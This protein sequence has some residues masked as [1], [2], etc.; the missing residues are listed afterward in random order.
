M[1]AGQ[2]FGKAG[3]FVSLMIFSRILEDAAFGELLLSVSIGL[4]IVFLSDMGVT[5]IVTRKMS[6]GE[7]TDGVFTDALVVRTLLSLLSITLVMSAVTLA[8]YSP[9]QVFLVLLVSIGFI[10]DGYCESTFALFRAREQMVYEGAVRVLH[11]I[12]GIGLSA[13]AWYSGKGVVFAASTYII[14]EI[15]ALMFA[16]AVVFIRMKYRPAPGKDIR[17][18]IRTLFIAAIP[19]GL[20]GIMIAAGQRLDSVFI[21]AFIGDAAIAAY[22]QCLK[23]FETLVLIVVPTLIPGALFPALC[24]AVQ[25]GWGQARMR[26]AWMTELFL[27][28]AFVLVIPLWAAGQNVLRVIWG[29]DFL[30]GVSPHDVGT[31]FKIVLL[32]LPV[33]YM[34]HMFMATVIAT[35][36]QRKVL[37]AVF[38]SLVLEALL[39]VLLIPRF[40]I[41][42]A[43][44]AHLLFLTTATFQMVWILKKAYG[45]T[46]FLRG[47]VRPVA[48]FIPA[49]AVLTAAPFGGILSGVSAIAVFTAV[50]I[51][52]GGLAIV[53]S[54]ARKK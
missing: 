31:T 14:R 28:I 32:T 45:P 34:F 40:G 49:V 9:R 35:N 19:L 25:D 51:L 41:P 17:R 8:G 43:A 10:L 36:R 5:M 20:A 33:A 2:V 24:M 11:G 39:F 7:P 15:P 4:I 21:K 54:K 26:I 16:F 37:S 38:L 46:G 53:P 48:S 50:W 42:G 47:A 12:L 1:L 3:L 18:R 13:F 6:T 27:V 22:Q 23:L 52:S 30:R 44:M 29:P